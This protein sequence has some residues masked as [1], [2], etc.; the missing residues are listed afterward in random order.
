MFK[1]TAPAQLR[2]VLDFWQRLIQDDVFVLATSIAYTATLS[3]FLLLVGLI[4]LLGRVVDQWQAQQA[5]VNA[6][7]PYLPPDGVTLVKGTLAAVIHT[8]GTVGVLATVGLF[9]GATAVAST[10]RHSLNRVL[11]V[12][13]ARPF[14]RR[15]LVEL[16]MV[17]LGG[18]FLSLSLVASG[19]LAM[20]ERIRSPDVAA[21]FVRRSL[22]LALTARAS[23]WIF[24]GLAF[25]AVYRFLPNLRFAWRSVLAAT[26]TA[27]LLFEGV[28][29]A[30]FW[31]L[32]TMADYPLVYGPLAVVVVFMIWVYLVA[33][34]VLI[35]AE[36]MVRIQAT[37][38]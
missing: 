16:A 11:R 19:I 22:A 17:L 13:R 20:V 9:W 31:Y 8:R 32:T 14:W 37:R 26:L 21:E 34:V 7:R 29:R 15:K 18:A 12:P 2:M 30:F 36:V 27:M 23:P 3:L 4:A 6:L 1:G 33:L 10:L 24:S 28:K 38:L 35:G 5:I 25:L